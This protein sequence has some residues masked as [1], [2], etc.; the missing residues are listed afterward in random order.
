M[1]NNLNIYS[2]NTGRLY[3]VGRLDMLMG[4][5]RKWKECDTQTAEWIKH[6]KKHYKRHIRDAVNTRW[7]SRALLL[8]S[9][10][11]PAIPAWHDP[12]SSP[13]IF[14]WSAGRE[15]CRD[16]VMEREREKEGERFQQTSNWFRSVPEPAVTG[17]LPAFHMELVKGSG[18]S[19]KNLGAQRR[20][21]T[22]QQHHAQQKLT[23]REHCQV[24]GG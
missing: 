15:R 7:T 21:Q 19:K 3:T 12:C 23:L 5:K 1:D 8:T 14:L 11:A 16:R 20:T 22:T 17:A 18:P 4:L 24:W 10:K 6:Y 9:M 13:Y 2:C